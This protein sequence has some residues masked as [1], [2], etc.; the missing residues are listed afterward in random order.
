MPTRRSP[1]SSTPRS[2]ARTARAFHDGPF[3][4]LKANYIDTGKVR[5]VYRE[6]Y[7]DRFGLWASMVA[8][9]GGPERYFGIVG[10]DL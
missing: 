2:P 9:C 3:K 7:F 1:W 5:F 6:V 4:E 10:P 8:R